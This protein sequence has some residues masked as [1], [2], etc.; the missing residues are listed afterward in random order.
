MSAIDMARSRH[1]MVSQPDPEQDLSELVADVVDDSAS[2]LAYHVNA[3][4]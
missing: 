1:A 3:A 2:C 4:S